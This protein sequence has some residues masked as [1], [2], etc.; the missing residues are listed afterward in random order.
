MRKRT[1][2]DSA[3]QRGNMLIVIVIYMTTKRERRKT[4]IE[5]VV[6]SFQLP[7][8]VRDLEVLQVGNPGILR[9]WTHVNQMK[10]T[11]HHLPEGPSSLGW[12][13]L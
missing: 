11:R 5:N 1:G 4:D 13:K 10:L 7:C 6:K 12:E 3:R 8:V 9:T 2:Q